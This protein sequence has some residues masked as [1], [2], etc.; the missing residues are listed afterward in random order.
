MRASADLVEDLDRYQPFHAAR[1]AFFRA[2]QAFD[3]ADAAY[4]RAIELSDNTA[5]AR[6]LNMK[7][8]GAKKEAELLLGLS[9][10]GR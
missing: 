10:T 4:A 2:A 3:A 6:F 8:D 1:A 9:P 5:S 7:R